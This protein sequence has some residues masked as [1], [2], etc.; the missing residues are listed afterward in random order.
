MHLTCAG[1]TWSRTTWDSDVIYLD[2]PSAKVI[3]IPSS[4]DLSIFPLK[5]DPHRTEGGGGAPEGSSSASIRELW[6][7]IDK[8]DEINCEAPFVGD[9]LGGALHERSS[10][11]SVARVNECASPRNKRALMDD[12]P[13]PS[14]TLPRGHGR[15]SSTN[16]AMQILSAAPGAISPRMRRSFVDRQYSPSTGTD[17]SEW[18]IILEELT[19]M[20]YIVKKA[21]DS[22]GGE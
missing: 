6:P 14:S 15:G 13:G 9:L 5:D 8:L 19:R 18:K 20:G 11:S 4:C 17:R 2:T 1:S 10:S 22:D 12:A 3:E 16:K 7:D 21:P